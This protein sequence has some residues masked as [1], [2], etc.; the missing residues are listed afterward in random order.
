MD[1]LVL[2]EKIINNKIKKL[3]TISNLKT[4]ITKIFIIA[5]TCYVISGYMFG[6]IR[7]ND[8][9]MSPYISEGELILYY[10]MAKVY[11]I[12]DV[13]IFKLNDKDYILRI[14]A[15]EGQTVEIGED[16]ELFVDGHTERHQALFK[17]VIP[18]NSTIMYPYK[19]KE[20]NYF[21]VGDYRTQT[22]DSRIFGAISSNRIKGKVISLLKTRNI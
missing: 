8:N 14:V 17:T 6:F 15:V 12:G 10:R 4:L 1:K 5:L 21:V 22:N 2:D 20:G 7:M 11:S 19:V 9:S 13:I 16:G 18:E 3:V